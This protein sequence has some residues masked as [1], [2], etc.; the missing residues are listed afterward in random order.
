[1]NN[2]NPAVIILLL[3]MVGALLVALRAMT[4]KRQLMAAQKGTLD[5]MAKTQEDVADFTSKGK[6]HHDITK[7][8]LAELQE[9]K[10]NLAEMKTS[11]ND[12]SK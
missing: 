7:Q 5:Q 12:R 10:R 6:E 1:M 2:V 3:V 11:V 4:L 9:I 8:I